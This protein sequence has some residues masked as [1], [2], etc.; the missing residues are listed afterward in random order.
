MKFSVVLNTYNASKHLRLVLESVKEADEIVICDMH[1]TDQTIS[2]AEEFNCKI[3]YYP[4]SGEDV[5]I[6]EPARNMAIQSAKNEWVLLLDADELVT[7]DL[8]LFCSDHMKQQQAAAGVFIPRKNYLHGVFMHA[9]YPDY[10]MRFF[11]K[12][13]CNWPPQIHSTPEIKGPAIKIPKEKRELAIVHLDDQNVYERIAK[14]NNYTSKDLN[15]L[16]KAGRSFSYFS[17]LYRLPF[18]FIKFY[19]IKGGYKDGKI[20]LVY[21][22]LHTFSR[23]VTMAKLWENEQ[24]KEK[25]DQR[26][27]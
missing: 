13:S 10:I 11:K 4:E 7:R 1:S 27:N 18:F 23:F 17:M 21:V 16:Q 2:I 9:S 19:L 25:Q 20:G 3:V 8:L 5:G 6:C 22:L 24:Q 12:D 26:I 14:L 15:R